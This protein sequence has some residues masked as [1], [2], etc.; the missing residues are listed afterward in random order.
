[1]RTLSR[2]GLLLLLLALAVQPLVA[3][4]STEPP[5]EAAGA[6]SGPLEFS[7]LN[8]NSLVQ[9][10]ESDYLKKAFEK[11]NVKINFINCD[12]SQAEQVNLTLASGTIPDVMLLGYLAGMDLPKLVDQDLIR[13]IPQEMVRKNAPYL[14]ALLERVEPTGWGKVMYQGKS[15]AVPLTFEELSLPYAG[16]IRSDWLQKVGITMGQ[17]TTVEELEAAFKAFVAKDPDGNGKSDTYALTSIPGLNEWQWGVI[18]GAWGV[19]PGNSFSVSGGKAVY[20]PAQAGY[21][22]ALKALARWY[23]AGTIDP[24]WV[25]DTSATATEKFANSKVGYFGGTIGQFDTDMLGSGYHPGFK[26]KQVNPSGTW[27]YVTQVKGPGGVSG[28]P[29]SESVFGWHLVLGKQVTDQKAA[30]IIRFYD[31]VN[32][33][34]E[35]WLIMEYWFEG[36]NYYIDPVT[37]MAKQTQ[38]QM[39]LNKRLRDERIGHVGCFRIPARR[40]EMS[41]LTWGPILNVYP[42]LPLAPRV[43]INFVPNWPT[44]TWKDLGADVQKASTTF[45]LNA[46][47][48]KLNIDAEWDGYVASLQK[49]KL[50]TMESEYNERYQHLLASA[51]K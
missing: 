11:L 43:S 46:V 19:R 3:S 9:K 6:S 15:Y 16:G 44:Q 28:A 1:M 32:S 50:S 8:A 29:A 36:V 22:D 49:L 24:E 48:G 13:E 34:R 26:L 14:T 30:A 41:L 20:S 7:F 31:D 47:T 17:V 18:F 37:G 21:R 4:G 5:K 35:K 25:T 45:A 40:M 12:G 27:Q 38:E 42:K 51:K 2:A 39:D 23:Q 33:N 10:P